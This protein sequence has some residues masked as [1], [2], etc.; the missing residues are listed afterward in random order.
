M[1]TEFY[2]TYLQPFR[3]VF[4]IRETFTSWFASYLCCYY[5]I[6][7]PSYYLGW[8]LSGPV[9]KEEPESPSSS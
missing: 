8:C 2:P 4:R 1:K 9:A 5:T 7:L 3:L 6:Y